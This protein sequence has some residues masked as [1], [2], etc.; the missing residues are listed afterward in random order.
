M[1]SHRSNS[2]S[3][4]LTMHDAERLRRLAAGARTNESRMALNLLSAMLD[5]QVRLQL[6]K[7]SAGERKPP[8]RAV[9]A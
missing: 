1:M 3:A 2:V 5:R 4:A 7:C 8:T 9:S 6:E